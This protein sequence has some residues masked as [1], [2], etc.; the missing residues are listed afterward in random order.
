L[1]IVVLVPLTILSRKWD[2][3]NNNSRNSPT[4]LKSGEIQS[5]TDFEVFFQCDDVYYEAH[6]LPN[7]HESKSPGYCDRPSLSAR[8]PHRSEIVCSE[9][10]QKMK[11]ER[12][13]RRDVEQESA[14]D[15]CRRITGNAFFL[16][17]V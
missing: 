15:F 5:S 14:K 8:T 4:T 10:Y 16:L 13:R 7:D 1:S 11:D 12:K 2:L 17:L 3:P 6:R 9:L